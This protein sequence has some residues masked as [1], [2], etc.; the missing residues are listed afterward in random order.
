MAN[1]GNI[2]PLALFQEDLIGIG[3]HALG[4]IDI[5]EGIEGR[6]ADGGLEEVL[7]AGVEGE[8]EGVFL[9]KMTHTPHPLMG[10]F[11][12]L[13]GG[14]ESTLSAQNRCPVRA[15]VDFPHL[16]IPVGKG[17]DHIVQDFHSASLSPRT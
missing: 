9:R 7:G 2:F 12:F 5:D 11:L 6:H 14:G 15:D 4:F 13:K 16:G 8:I 1:Y 3:L 17:I 10:M